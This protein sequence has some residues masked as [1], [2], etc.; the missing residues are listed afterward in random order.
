[1]KVPVRALKE[2][3][4][5]MLQLAK[6]NEKDM[7]EYLMNNKYHLYLQTRAHKTTTE[8]W[9]NRVK[10]IIERYEDDEV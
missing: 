9:A 8:F 5:R 2:L 3:E 1:M 4:E 7:T 10:E 6:V